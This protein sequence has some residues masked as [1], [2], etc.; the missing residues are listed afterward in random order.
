MSHDPIRSGRYGQVCLCPDGGLGT[1]QVQHEDYEDYED[2]KHYQDLDE[3]RI[4]TD[5][6]SIIPIR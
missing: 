1:N 6:C 5:A 4:Y 2:N 3:P